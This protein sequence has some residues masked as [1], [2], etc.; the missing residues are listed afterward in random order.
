MHQ[1]NG[2]ESVAADFIQIRGKA[3]DGI[4]ARAVREWALTLPAEATVL[5]VGCGTGWPISKVLI[6]MKL[7][8]YGI[9][10]SPTLVDVFRQHFPG[11]PVA[12]EAVEDSSFFNKKFNGVVAWGLLFLLPENQQ[13]LVVS[14]LCEALR[15]GGKFL[16]TAP[17]QPVEWKDVL[18]GQRSVSLGAE[19]YSQLLAEG[20]LSILGEDTDD[21]DNYYYSAVKA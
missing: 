9:D 3:E 16:F 10:A 7:S 18:T 12:C 5:D 1:S 15:V 2:Y 20:G 17:Y 11:V 21:G 6:D 8:V 13:E 4:G 14:R 19:R